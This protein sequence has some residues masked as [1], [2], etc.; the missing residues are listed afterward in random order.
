MAGMCPVRSQRGQRLSSRA[1]AGG[2]VAVVMWGLAPVATRAVVAHIAP[3]PLLAL[4]MGLA[5]LVLLPWAV[6]VFRRLTLRSAARLTAAGALGIVGYTLPV[7]VGLQWLRASTAGLLLASE[8]IWVMLIC[9]VFLSERRPPRAWAGSGVALAGVVLLA[10]PTVLTGGAPAGGGPAG[11]HRALAG[12]GLVLAGTLAFGAY[13]VV[14]RPLSKV[15]GAGPATAASTV[16]GAVPFLAFAGTIS[17]SRLTQLPPSA[18]AELAFLGLGSSVAGMLLWNHAVAIAGS[19][20]VSLLLYLE[21]VVSVTG[22]VALLG[23]HVTAAMLGAG[24]LILAGVALASAGIPAEA[25]AGTAEAAAG[26]AGLARPAFARPG[27]VPDEGHIGW[28]S[29]E[30]HS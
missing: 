5:S 7:T 30:Q 17:G 13:T 9:R 4:R 2:L 20:R 23:E 29:D 27:R 8:P 16:I 15:H 28:E 25:A 24:A 18:W 19:S 22:A 14:L 26:T 1:L 10:G 3:L 12:A 11:G 6:P 21:P